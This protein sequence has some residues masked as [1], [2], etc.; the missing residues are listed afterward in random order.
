[1]QRLGIHKIDMPEP[2]FLIGMNPHPTINITL[3]QQKEMSAASAKASEWTLDVKTNAEEGD[4][5]VINEHTVKF[6]KTDDESGNV[7]LIG[8]SAQSTAEAIKGA[9]VAMYALDD[10]ITV[11]AT[12][13]KIT[14]KEKNDFAGALDFKVF[15]KGTLKIEFKQTVEGNPAIPTNVPAGYDVKAGTILYEQVPGEYAPAIKFAKDVNYLILADDANSING[16]VNVNAYISGE[17]NADRLKAINPKL[18]V[19]EGTFG[20]GNQLILKEVR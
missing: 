5:L 1:M 18:N 7:V 3:R 11:T 9:L 2:G 13:T 19:K 15:A 6:A 17:F 10:S 12:T 4:T 16:D 14:I 8:D 20:K